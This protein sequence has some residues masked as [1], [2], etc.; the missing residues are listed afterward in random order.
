MS[1]GM[2]LTGLFVDKELM[3]VTELTVRLKADK[4]FSAAHVRD[5][6]GTASPV[7]AAALPELFRPLNAAAITRV[8]VLTQEIKD[9]NATHESLKDELSAYKAQG[10]KAAHAVV[11][12]VENPEVDDKKTAEKCKEIALQVLMPERERQR[13]AALVALAKAQA[14]AD[15]FAE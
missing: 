7:D 1:N 11:A 2:A 14:E 4:T 15:K 9:L 3:M 8:D 6:K 5:A 13:Q 10:I 12:V